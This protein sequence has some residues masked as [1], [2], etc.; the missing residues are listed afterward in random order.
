M[1]KL[2]EINTFNSKMR[3]WWSA[4]KEYLIK[5]L[6]VDTERGLLKEQVDSHRRSFGAN[7]L[8]EIKL[9]RIWELILD[10]VK[11]PMMILLLSIAA[12]SL[13]FGK[14]AE[15]IVMVFVVA[16][17]I[18]VEFI[19]KFRTDR[20]MA[21]LR[22][23]TQPMTKVIREGRIQEIHT[24]DVVVGDVAVLSEGV[25]IPADIRLIESFGL[26]VNEAPLTG[27]SF[28]VQKND[29]SDSGQDTPLAERRNCV[30]SGTII[31]AGEGKGIVMAV[32][33]KNELGIIARQ[34]QAQKRTRPLSRKP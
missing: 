27:E 12:L 33:N 25:R 2:T 14:P 13:L 5:S 3:F 16:A 17:Y 10:G 32:G 29:K 18:S 20:T 6:S 9:T 21:R 4:S 11:E 1:N 8:E 23:L 22:E 26:L 7:T 34:V 15:A 19:N 24:S 30:F 31:L 28:P